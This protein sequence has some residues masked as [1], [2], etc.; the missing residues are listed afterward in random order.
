MLLREG[1]EDAEH[2]EER[3]TSA[4]DSSLVSRGEVTICFG[5]FPS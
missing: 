4:P 3:K 1:R 5:P 2:R